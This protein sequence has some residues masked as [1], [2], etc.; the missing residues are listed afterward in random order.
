MSEAH[1]GYTSLHKYVITIVLDIKKGAGNKFVLISFA[2]FT[3]LI[4]DLEFKFKCY[5]FKVSEIQL[6]NS[7]HAVS[8]F[9]Q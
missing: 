1:C 4:K 8:A 9:L 3:D 2:I 6:R 5:Y 7:Y